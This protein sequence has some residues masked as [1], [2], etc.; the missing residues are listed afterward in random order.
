MKLKIEN[1][2][3]T[4][5]IYQLQSSDLFM[6]MDSN[7]IYMLTDNKEY[8]ENLGCYLFTCVELETGHIVLAEEDI[9]VREAEAV[10]KVKNF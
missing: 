9:V 7:T 2:T 1:V 5:K 6:K 10:L 8:A 4:K 3:E